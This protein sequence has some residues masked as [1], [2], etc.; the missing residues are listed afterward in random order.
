MFAIGSNRLWTRILTIRIVSTSAVCISFLQKENRFRSAST[1]PSTDRQ[2][3]CNGPSRIDIGS[4]ERNP[5]ASA[6]LLS[7]SK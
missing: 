5:L 7:G 4:V 6:G 2:E 1:M 3:T